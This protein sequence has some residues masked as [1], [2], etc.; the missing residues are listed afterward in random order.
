MKLIA[1]I[2]S[3]KQFG[4]WDIHLMWES[5]IRTIWK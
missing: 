1:D 5:Y 3:W 4:N 2:N